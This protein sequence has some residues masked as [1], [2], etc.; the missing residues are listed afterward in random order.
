MEV[1][2]VGDAFFD[3]GDV[4]GLKMGH[5]DAVFGISHGAEVA[6]QGRVDGVACGSD[7][8]EWV[9]TDFVPFLSQLFFADIE[10]DVVAVFD[11]AV[12]AVQVRIAVGGAGLQGLC[13]EGL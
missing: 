13:G 4:V 6:Q 3:G 5:A 12:V 9:G 7:G 2:G 8:V 11:E 10:V 1:Y